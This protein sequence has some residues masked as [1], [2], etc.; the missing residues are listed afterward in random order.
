MP[1][2]IPRGPEP[3]T[4]DPA[5]AGVLPAE[6]GRRGPEVAADDGQVELDDRL[7]RAIGIPSFGLSIPHLTGL[8]GDIGPGDPRWWFGTVWF[9]ALSAAIWHGNRW[10]LFEQRRHW[11]WFRH[12]PR[13]VI[14][15]LAAIV[16]YTAPLTA[17]AL[18]AWYAWSGRGG[19]DWAVVRTVVLINV[20]CVVFVTHVYE[21]VFLIKDRGSDMLRVAQLERAR[22]EAELAAFRAQLDPH[23]VFN[24]L[25][26]LSHLVE[27]DPQRAREFNERLA[28]IYRYMLRQRVGDLVALDDELELVRDY[29]WLL[30]IRFGDA[31]ALRISGGGAAA[32]VPPMSLQLLVENAV[33]HNELGADRPLEIDIDVR[34]RE[35]SVSTSY[36]PRR[37]LRPSAGVG[38]RNLDER[39]R[40]L[41]AGAI[42]IRPGPDRFEVTLPLVEPA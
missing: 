15:L 35:V 40:L 36:R 17:C 8:F 11:D 34:A 33:K 39:Y 1:A 32:R 26:T 25:N 28:D 31:I 14:M 10:L 27:T 20:L 38:L 22:A 16:L 29:V 37:L 9:V 13:K 18:I 12:G 24:S 41:G 42:Q 23:F 30:R 19:A 21:T 6:G 7:V 2:A 3:G 5:E 4:A